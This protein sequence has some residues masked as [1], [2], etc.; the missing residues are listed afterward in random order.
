MMY[1]PP[2]N[3]ILN[4]S[5]EHVHETFNMCYEVPSCLNFGDAYVWNT[6]IGVNVISMRLF[7]FC[8]QHAFSV[9]VAR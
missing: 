5:T 4:I 1:K 8:R 7:S 6:A 3:D 9:I 2:Y